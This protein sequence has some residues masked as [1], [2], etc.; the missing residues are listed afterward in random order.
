M[1]PSARRHVSEW[2]PTIS[3]AVGVQSEMLYFGVSEIHASLKSTHA[4]VIMLSCFLLALGMFPFLGMT[5][6]TL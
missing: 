4:L 5:P 1:P 6:A 3:S 2:T